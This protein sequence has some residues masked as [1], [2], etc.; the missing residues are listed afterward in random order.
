MSRIVG[1]IKVELGACKLE[2]SGGGKGLVWTRL[3]A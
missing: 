1:E 2:G 3:R